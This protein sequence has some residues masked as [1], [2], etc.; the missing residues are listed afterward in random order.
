MVLLQLLESL[1]GRKQNVHLPLAHHLQ[2]AIKDIFIKL[3]LRL[4]CHTFLKVNYMDV[5]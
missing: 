2:P 1:L 4:K 5:T 3:Q